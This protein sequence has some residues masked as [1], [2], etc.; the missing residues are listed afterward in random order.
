MLKVHICTIFVPKNAAVSVG[1]AVGRFLDVRMSLRKQ[2]SPID[3][4]LLFLSSRQITTTD[5]PFYQHGNVFLIINNSFINLASS[6][7]LDNIKHY[8]LFSVLVG[9]LEN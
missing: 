4:Y 8:S 3:F 5:L 6:S 9:N 1:T 7:L 2:L